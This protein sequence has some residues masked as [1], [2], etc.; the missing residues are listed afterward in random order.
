MS[1][2]FLKIKMCYVYSQ[3]YDI[4]CA[5]LYN[6]TRICFPQQDLLHEHVVNVKFM[7]TSP[8]FSFKT[9]EAKLVFIHSSFFRRVLIYHK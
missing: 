5:T 7:R 8:V 3:W 1:D 9:M 2:A 4:S 6:T